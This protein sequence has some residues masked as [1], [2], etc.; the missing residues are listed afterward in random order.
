[1]TNPIPS[2]RPLTARE[3]LSLPT[4]GI[5]FIAELH[6]DDCEDTSCVRCV[7]QP[8]IAALDVPLP[9]VEEQVRTAAGSRAEQAHLLDPAD[10]LFARLACQSDCC[11]T[12]SGDPT[13]EA[14]LAQRIADHTQA[15]NAHH[16]AGGQ[17]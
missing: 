5:P 7:D 16:K 2:G 3:F 6:V 15:W 11:G 17:A 1:M 14:W 4:S 13:W 12:E 10:P 8:Q 9:V